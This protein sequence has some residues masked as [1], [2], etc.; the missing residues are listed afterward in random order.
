MHGHMTYDIAL[1]LALA[2]A[3]AVAVFVIV[4][5]MTTSPLAGTRLSGPVRAHA[6]HPYLASPTLILISS[7]PSPSL[8]AFLNILPAAP[9]APHT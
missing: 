7:S 6:M 8:S 3:L 2:L 4:I 9:T 1:A 5:V